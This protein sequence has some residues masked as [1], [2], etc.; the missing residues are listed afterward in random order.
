VQIKRST[1]PVGLL[2]LMAACA[3]LPEE[4]IKKSHKEI[5]FIITPQKNELE[6]A[7]TFKQV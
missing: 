7:V 6:V 5:F 1:P 3:T 4:N 2:Q